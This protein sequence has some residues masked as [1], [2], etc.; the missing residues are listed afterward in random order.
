[1]FFAKRIVLDCEKMH[2]KQ[3]AFEHINEKI[4]FLNLPPKNLDSL[5][6]SL[7]DMKKCRIIIKNYSNANDYC[8]AIISVIDN[9]STANKNIKA[10]IYR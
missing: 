4:S 6:D 3:T 9:N 2:S 8:R 1:M 10:V 5:N 7:F